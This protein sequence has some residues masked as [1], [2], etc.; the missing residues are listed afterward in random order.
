MLAIGAFCARSDT[1]QIA[2]HF[3]NKATSSLGVDHLEAGTLLL[4]QAFTLLSN[5]TQKRNRLNAG[6]VYLGEFSLQ[7]DFSRQVLLSGWP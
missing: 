6:S 4:V 5:L 2:D 1:P 3:L 7:S